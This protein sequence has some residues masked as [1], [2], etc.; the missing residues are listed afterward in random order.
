MGEN[1]DKVNDLKN[2]RPIVRWAF[3]AEQGQLSDVFEC[4]DQFIVAALTE[5]NEGEYR[6]IDEV[7]A[8]LT[9]QAKA[10]KKAEY[11]T[12]QLKNV[13][14]LEEAAELFD[15]EIQTAED[16]TLASSRLGAA[17]VEPAVVG[18][19]LALENNATSGPIKGNVGVYMVRIGEKTVAEGELNAEQEIAQLNTRTSYT[20]PYQAIALIEE[21][22]KVEDN[23]A[24]FQ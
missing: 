8:E 17:G 21:K 5:V 4:G 12:N 22:A 14:T 15:A 2:S 20:I 9:M 7:R 23:R 10:D 6:T 18:A 19:A 16:I 1:S 3:E 13:T 11:I 24:R